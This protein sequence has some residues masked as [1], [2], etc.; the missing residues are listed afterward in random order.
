M[1]PDRGGAEDRRI[2]VQRA[3]LLDRGLDRL[4]HLRDPPPVQRHHAP[5]FGPLDLNAAVGHV[6]SEQQ[7]SAQAAG[8]LLVFDPDPD[9]PMAW[10]ERARIELA[11]RHLL[12]NAIKHTPAGLIRV[13]TCERVDRA[14][15]RISDT[16]L[17]VEAEE[18]PNLFERFYRTRS[19]I[20]SGVAGAGLGLWI[21]QE[22][23]ELHGGEI[24]AENTKEGGAKFIFTLPLS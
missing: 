21:V 7:Q 18:V 11:V 22:I 24:R 15:V 2:R 20:K 1:W 8:H 9:L 17:G 3:H 10:G 16:G 4:H 5:V 19:A 23:V 14:C 6:V 13:A 12:D